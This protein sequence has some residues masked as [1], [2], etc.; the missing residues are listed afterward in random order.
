[1]D[2]DPAGVE[3]SVANY[4]QVALDVYELLLLWNVDSKET[5]SR[6]TKKR[7][8]PEKKRKKRA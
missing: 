5:S 8:T 1:M 6:K 7:Y 3:T 4:G 2:V